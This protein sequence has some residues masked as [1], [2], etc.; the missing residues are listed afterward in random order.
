MHNF[1][2]TTFSLK[3]GN[4]TCFYSALEAMKQT[5]VS[6][7]KTAIGYLLAFQTD[8]HI[9]DFVK[10]RGWVV[11]LKQVYFLWEQLCVLQ[12]VSLRDKSQ[13]SI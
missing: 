10:K 9:S 4:G 13:Q 11:I 3:K 2:Q 12:I 1:L 6:V 7:K 5:S 8:L